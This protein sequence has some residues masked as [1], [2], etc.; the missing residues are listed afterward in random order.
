[1]GN[2]KHRH[3]VNRPSNIF[4]PTDPS[5]YNHLII[6][7]GESTPGTGYEFSLISETDCTVCCEDDYRLI[8]QDSIVQSAPSS[9]Y[10]NQSLVYTDDLDYKF[11]TTT[12]LTLVAD[13]S[14]IDNTINIEVSYQV[15]SDVS[16]IYSGIGGIVCG[17]P[18]VGARIRDDLIYSK[19]TNVTQYNNKYTD[20]MGE[21]A[22]TYL[23]G[24]SYTDIQNDY[25]NYSVDPSGNLN[26]TSIQEVRI[27]PANT[28]IV[29]YYE[30]EANMSG[31]CEGM[32]SLY[33]LLNVLGYVNNS[34]GTSVVPEAYSANISY[35]R[36][37]GYPDA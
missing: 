31:K 11:L 1:M 4:D 18:G 23:S 21:V 12:P 8:T 2:L 33:V 29:N 30:L 26:G 27:V 6:S 17:L 10:E 5:Q 16:V 22:L 28:E 14:I 3:G 25:E 35:E 15:E 20:S 7:S 9:L 36:C 24:F 13:A 19:I 34:P 32:H 37:S